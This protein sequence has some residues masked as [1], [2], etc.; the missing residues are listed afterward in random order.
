MDGEWKD[1]A[2]VAPEAALGAPEWVVSL[3]A[4]ARRA[5]IDDPRELAVAVAEART[6]P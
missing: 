4:S 3:S 2:I 5:S 1:Y 6:S